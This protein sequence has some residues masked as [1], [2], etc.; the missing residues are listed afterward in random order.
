MN[1]PLHLYVHWPWCQSKCPYCDFNSHALPTG[2]LSPATRENYVN[3]IIDEIAWWRTQIAPNRPIS[4]VFFG[5]GTPSLMQPEELKLILSAAQTLGVWQAETEV[6]LECNP[7]S[8][9]EDVG[10]TYFQ[11]IQS[12]GINRLSI[13]VQGLRDDWL[14][15][16][17]RK[18]SASNALA[19]LAAA[20]K[21]FERVNA[22]VIYGLPQ[23]SLI[24]WEALLVELAQMGLGHIAAYQLTV[25]RHTVFWGQVQRKA[26][27]PLDVDTQAEFFDLTRTVLHTY[28]YD[29]YEISNFSQPNNTCHHN[30]GVWRGEDYLGVGAGAHGR[31][32][33]PHGVRMATTTRKMPEAYL[34]SFCGHTDHFITWQETDF[35]S[36]IQEALFTGLRLKEGVNLTRLQK[37]YPAASWGAAIAIDEFNYLQKQKYIQTYQI[38]NETYLQ[39]TATGWSKLDGVLQ[40]LLTPISSPDEAKTFT[41]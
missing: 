13:G 19:T 21:V 20:Q 39:L 3:K 31:I 40:Y 18:H 26:W 17:G 33:L 32:T 1:A 12:A 9:T 38:A 8:L 6:T 10:H 27:Q 41:S 11:D 25:E 22:D 29:N 36:L 30:L 14:A 34:A 37:I 35:I 5:G 16:L 4:S 7:T 15:F 2:G 23:Q 24:E 28:G